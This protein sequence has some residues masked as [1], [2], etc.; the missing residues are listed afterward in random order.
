MGFSKLEQI[1]MIKQAR[2]EYGHKFQ[3]Q[4]RYLKAPKYKGNVKSHDVSMRVDHDQ[5]AI[6]S[7]GVRKS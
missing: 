6:D 5:A 4:P 1:Y 3:T 2:K 7:E